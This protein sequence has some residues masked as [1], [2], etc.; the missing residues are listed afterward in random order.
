MA[1]IYKR[2]P[3]QYQAVVRL[4]GAKR[5]TKTFESRREAEVWAAGVE[6]DIRR[7]SFIDRRAAQK[8]TFRDILSR[9][10]NEVLPFK[11][12]GD[13]ER[14]RIRQLKKHY[15]AEKWLSDLGPQDFSNF[16]DERLKEVSPATVIR[17]LGVISA[18]LSCAIKDWG[19]PIENPI[20]RIRRP[21]EPEHRSRRL[22]GG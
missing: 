3:Y 18:V 11:R 8:V 9:Y 13:A 22:V 15:I 10:E 16:R 2:G 6:A 7:N 4:K 19:Y 21:E 14:P 12:G 1:S 17:E 20:P 5:Q